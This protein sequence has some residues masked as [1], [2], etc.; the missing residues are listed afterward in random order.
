M[1]FVL[2]HIRFWNGSQ[3]FAMRSV[4]SEDIVVPLT[5]KRQKFVDNDFN[6][7]KRFLSQKELIYKTV[8]QDFAFVG[9]LSPA[10]DFSTIFDVAGRFKKGHLPGQFVLCGDGSEINALR[11]MASGLD[12]VIFTG[13]VSAAEMNALFS[14]TTAS[15]APYRN[16]ED[17]KQSIP[18]KIIDALANSLPILTSLQG[19]VKS[20]I[21]TAEAGSI[22]KILMI[23]TDIVCC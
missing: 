4:C 12:N 19:E 7:S 17:F 14:V 13:W 21:Q 11:K 20:L 18:N 8:N 2:F 16:S 15:L 23:F 9:S 22:T 6:E 5:T 10:F 3:N 1:R